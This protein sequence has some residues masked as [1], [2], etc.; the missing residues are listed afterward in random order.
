MK[1]ENEF[2]ISKFEQLETSNGKILQGGF[3]SSNTG[4]GIW[5]WIRDLFTETNERCNINNCLE[6]CMP[7]CP[8]P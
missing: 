2:E 4:T 3:S 5:D 6:N 8:P 1:K 7:G